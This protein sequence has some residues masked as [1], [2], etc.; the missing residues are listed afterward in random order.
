MI[1]MLVSVS[2]HVYAGWS[3]MLL[4]QLL[5]SAVVLRSFHKL[6]LLAELS[7]AGLQTNLKKR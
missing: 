6:S 3:G 4:Q 1:L 7:I 5:S 2:D